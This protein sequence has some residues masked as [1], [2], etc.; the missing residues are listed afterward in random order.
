MR[1]TTLGKRTRSSCPATPFEELELP[2]KRPRRQTRNF[3]VNDENAD[4]A[5]SI[6]VDS[7]RGS[8]ESTADDWDVSVESTPSKRRTKPASVVEAVKYRT[9]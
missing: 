7:G 3:Q 6:E 5:E 8:E 2:S 9:L 4:P 1:S